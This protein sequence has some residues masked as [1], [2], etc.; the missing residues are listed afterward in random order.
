MIECDKE[1]DVWTSV[2]WCKAVRP[3][4]QFSVLTL[5]N[6]LARHSRRL[7]NFYQC[8]RPSLGFLYYFPH[9]ALA[10]SEIQYIVRH[11]EPANAQPSGPPATQAAAHTRRRTRRRSDLQPQP[12]PP[13]RARDL[14][15][16]PQRQPRRHIHPI[17]IG[18]DRLCCSIHW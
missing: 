14:T 16:I 3:H 9:K 10:H 7:D 18:R 13:H 15:R 5:R 11:D 8:V 4:M 6:H 12:G 17:L 1:T 2:W